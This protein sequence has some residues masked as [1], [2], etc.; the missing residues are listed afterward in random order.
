MHPTRYEV[1]VSWCSS[2]VCVLACEFR[3]GL[4]KLLGRV[5][6]CGQVSAVVWQLCG[7][8]HLSSSLRDDLVKVSI[9][10]MLSEPAPSHTVYAGC[11]GVAEG[12][13]CSQIA[14]W[15]G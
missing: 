12:S 14:A 11:A 13:A 10:H 4:G 15:L 6:S 2:H 3:E 7:Q 1:S 5:V 8:F 9:G